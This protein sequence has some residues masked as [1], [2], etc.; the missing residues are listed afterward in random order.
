MGLETRHLT[1]PHGD[2]VWLPPPTAVPQLK[3]V[4]VLGI[5]LCTSIGYEIV[6]ARPFARRLVLE[7]LPQTWETVYI[8]LGGQEV[9]SSRMRD[10]VS[11]PSR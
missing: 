10:S 7:N 5:G 2:S 11:R 9:A 6:A 3:L 1:A 8:F 4:A